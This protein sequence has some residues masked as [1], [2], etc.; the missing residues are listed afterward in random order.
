MKPILVT[1]SSGLIGHR[2]VA[3]LRCSGETVVEYDIARGAEDVRDPHS[4]ERAINGCRGVIHLAA[5]SRVIDGERDPHE[6][7]DVNVNGTA[8][9]C[10]QAEA[11]GAW[12]MYA[13]SR[14]V[15]GV[16]SKIVTED[17]DPSPINAYGR[18]KLD[19]ERVIFDSNCNTAIVRL[20]NVYGT[21][22][23]HRDRVVPAFMAAAKDGGELRVN[24]FATF[25]FVHVSEVVRGIL[26][27]TNSLDSGH[28]MPVMHFVSGTGTTLWDLAGMCVS[29][30]PDSGAQVS[31]GTPRSFDVDWFVGENIVADREI[32]WRSGISLQEGMTLMRDE[33]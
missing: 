23:D 24:G 13:S 4:L 8:N 16:Q 10:R 22:H 30:Y 31:L 14:E 29:M 1:G 3:T 11:A 33:L 6:C 7:W 28:S 25:D 19:A 27:G 2:L 5:K 18:S 17:V 32:G 26:L 12:V 9:V 20:S 21:F 15:Y